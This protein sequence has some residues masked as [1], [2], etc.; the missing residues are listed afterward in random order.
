MLLMTTGSMSIDTGRILEEDHGLQEGIVDQ[1]VDQEVEDDDLD[2][3][4]V[5]ILEV[6]VDNFIFYYFL[7]SIF[8]YF[9]YFIFITFIFYFII[10]CFYYISLFL[11]LS[12]YFIKQ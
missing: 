9:L 12:L 1:E 7:H 4:R 6:V 3:E 10:Y 8:Y 2:P 11:L 5:L